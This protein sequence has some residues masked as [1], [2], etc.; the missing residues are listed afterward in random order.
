MRCIFSTSLGKMFSLEAV[1]Y[2]FPV[3]T[4]MEEGC[5]HSAQQEL[6]FTVL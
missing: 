4:V 2:S 6:I 5:R 1:D 3:S